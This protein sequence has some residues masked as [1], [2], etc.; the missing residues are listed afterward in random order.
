M[1]VLELVFIK[2]KNYEHYNRALGKHIHSKKH[3]QEECAR[4]GMISFDRA[5]LLASK[6]RIES[7]AK[8]KKGISK[9]AY[10]IIKAAKLRAD[11]KG[12]VKLGDRT[13]DAIKSLGKMRNAPRNVH[14]RKWDWE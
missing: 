11:K 12:N 2:V 6:S 7:E 5:E 1:E 4:Q 3:Y 10:E 13:I 8:Q 14:K 9:K